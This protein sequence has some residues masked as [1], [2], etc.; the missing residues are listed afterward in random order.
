MTV[1]LAMEVPQKHA[2]RGVTSGK[3]GRH[4]V[5]AA[6]LAAGRG[7]VGLQAIVIRGAPTGEARNRIVIGVQ[8]ADGNMVLRARRSAV[9]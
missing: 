7:H 6:D 4:A 2:I 9:V 3:A 8:S 1:G 5:V